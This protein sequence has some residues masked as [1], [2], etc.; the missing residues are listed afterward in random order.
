MSNS[1]YSKFRK[2][3]LQET[4]HPL[5]VTHGE[6]RMFKPDSHGTIPVGPDPS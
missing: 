5:D 1:S 2:R 4:G 3:G 6:I